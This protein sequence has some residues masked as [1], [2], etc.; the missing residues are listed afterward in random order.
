MTYEKNLH[1]PRSSEDCSWFRDANDIKLL[2]R[3]VIQ[4]TSGLVPP[5]DLSNC[6]RLTRPW[7]VGRIASRQCRGRSAEE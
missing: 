2:I 7:P 3:R 1:V 4:M 6:T 5:E